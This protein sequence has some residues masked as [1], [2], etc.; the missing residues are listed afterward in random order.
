MAGSK[1]KLGYHNTHHMVAAAA[2]ANTS[3]D[4]SHLGKK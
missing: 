2:V 3:E 1:Q 4:L